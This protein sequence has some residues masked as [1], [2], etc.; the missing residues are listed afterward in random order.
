MTG[1]ASLLPLGHFGPIRQARPMD[2]RADAR[3][4]RPVH[5]VRIRAFSQWKL[6]AIAVGRTFGRA[7]GAT[8]C[9]LDARVRARG[10][11]TPEVP[12]AR[13]PTGTGPRG[14]RCSEACG[15]VAPAGETRFAARSRPSRP[16]ETRPSEPGT[17]RY[18]PGRCRGSPLA[19]F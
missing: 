17:S 18:R 11:T 15:A 6:R 3:H 2:P 12:S 13:I 7:H 1:V 10:A 9:M 14:L 4:L 16:E 8:R 5:F 19:E